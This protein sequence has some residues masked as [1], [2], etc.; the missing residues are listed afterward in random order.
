[1][2][3][4]GAWKLRLCAQVTDEAEDLYVDGLKLNEAPWSDFSAVV[5]RDSTVDCVAF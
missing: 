5:E 3:N 1:V 2:T 4:T